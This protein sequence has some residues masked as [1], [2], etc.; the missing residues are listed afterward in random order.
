MLLLED[1]SIGKRLTARFSLTL[2]CRS[3]K[4]C[5]FCSIETRLFQSE[6]VREDL[7]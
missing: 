3:G 5:T 4:S 6:K 1:A 2:P 7:V